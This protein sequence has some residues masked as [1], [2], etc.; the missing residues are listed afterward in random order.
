MFNIIKKINQKK[1]FYIGLIFFYLIIFLAPNKIIYFSAYFIASCFFYIQTRKIEKSLIYSLALAVFSELGTNGNIIVF[2]LFILSLLPFSFKQKY[3]KITFPDIF[4][5]LFFIWS[6]IGILFHPFDETI[7]GIAVLSEIICLYYLLRIHLSENDIIPISIVCI[8]M[9]LFQTILG[10]FQLS[11]GRNI[12]LLTEATTVTYP[13]GLTASEDDNLFRVTASYGHANMYAVVLISALPFL[14]IFSNWYVYG[15]RLLWI[16]NLLFTHSRVAWLLGFLMFGYFIFKEHQSIHKQNMNSYILKLIGILS[17]LIVLAPIFL[18]RI[19]T[20]S[21]A[22]EDQGSFG[23]RLKLT[24]EALNIISQSPIIGIGINRFQEIASYNPITDIFPVQV[25]S[26]ASNIH[27]L[28]L[29]M[30]V[31]SGI[32]ALMF[33]ILFLISIYLNYF[34]VKSNNQNY[35][36]KYFILSLTGLILISL[37]HPIYLVNQFRLFFLFSALIL[38]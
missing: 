6:V 13:Y 1:Y 7:L 20:V 38:I 15:I 21:Q 32:P 3:V 36:K 22:L 11:S 24:Q 18:V 16:I 5:I 10:I 25:Y 12:G 29:E 26:A 30:A 23:Y 19:M 28:F 37:F 2:G 31:S 33:F 27:N 9:L 14:F 17:V 35:F 34:K 4:V 8:S